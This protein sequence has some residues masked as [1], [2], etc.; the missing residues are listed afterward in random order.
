MHETAYTGTCR[1]EVQEEEMRAAA[2][3]LKQDALD[4]LA[5]YGMARATA[6]GAASLRRRGVM[7]GDAT[8]WNYNRAMM[9]LRA[10][11]QPGYAPKPKMTEKPGR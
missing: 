11:T 1:R 7:D 10:I 2:E 5:V 4:K 8:D 3:R 6:C 9:D